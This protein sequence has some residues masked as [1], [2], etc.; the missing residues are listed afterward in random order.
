MTCT[1]FTTST[2]TVHGKDFAKFINFRDCCNSAIFAKFVLC[3]KRS[4]LNGIRLILN[5]IT[6]DNHK[7]IYF[8]QIETFSSALRRVQSILSPSFRDCFLYNTRYINDRRGGGVPVPCFDGASYSTPTASI[9]INCHHTI[10]AQH[11]TCPSVN[12]TQFQWCTSR[13]IVNLDL[14]QSTNT[15]LYM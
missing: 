2:T 5:K 10:R 11:L 4:P 6:N 13:L 9:W 15:G 7:I 1:R 14:Q 12:R 8:I 3:A